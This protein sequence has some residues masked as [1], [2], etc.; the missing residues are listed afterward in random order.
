MYVGHTYKQM[1]LDTSARN[2]KRIFTSRVL[3]PSIY[4]L[5]YQATMYVS[6]GVDDPKNIANR[7]IFSCLDHLIVQVKYIYVH[8][9]YLINV[10][11]NIRM[12][13]GK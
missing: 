2:R 4:E 8:C 7:D 5:D 13:V 11:I 6:N 9:T 12:Q 1:I 10:S 3:C